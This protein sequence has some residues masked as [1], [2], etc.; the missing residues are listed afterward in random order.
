MKAVIHIGSAK[1]GTTTIQHFLDKNRES[2]KKQMIFVPPGFSA[3]FPAHHKLG[4]ATYLP[5]AW[6]SWPIFSFLGH[7]HYNTFVRKDFPS[8][9]KNLSPKDQE[10]LW[11]GYRNEIEANCRQDDLVIFS[12][13]MFCLFLENEVERVKKLMDSLFDDVTI[14]LYLRRHPEYLVSAHHSQVTSGKPWNTLDFCNMPANRSELA[15]HKTVERWSAFGKDK[16]KIRLFDKREFHDNDL[17]SDFAHTVGFDMTE[18]E[19]VENQNETGLDSAEA[20]FLRLLNSH[21]PVLLD[22]WTYNPDRYSLPGLFSAYSR[23][24]SVKNKKAYHLT[25]SEARQ[26]L[27]QCREGND[28]IAREYLG[29]EKLFDEDVSMYPEEVD[30]P[31]GLTL[32]KCAEITAHLWKDRCGVIRQLQQE[33]DVC[34]AE[35]HQLQQEKDA[36]AAEI[37]RLQDDFLLQNNKYIYW[38][39]YRC[40]L[41]AKLTFGK[42]RKHYKA[43]RNLFHD[44]VRR[45]RNLRK[46]K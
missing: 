33:K 35:I 13:E 30:S 45:I 19:R 2:L 22:P 4:V 8:I 24:N 21:I 7:L 28:W 23:K 11:V 12:S 39:Y 15:Y 37:Q 32:E 20:E 43:K 10:K 46:L 27:D 31:H 42:K 36:H 3:V 18:L 38:Q 14:V 1:T 34:A 6:E 9:E 40:K 16:L 44:Q 5:D 17:L 41:L 29:R 25:R 26:I